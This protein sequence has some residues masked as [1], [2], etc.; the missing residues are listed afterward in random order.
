MVLIGIVSLVV[1][2]TGA[3][4]ESLRVQE[5]ACRIQEDLFYAQSQAVVLRKPHCVVFDTTQGLYH[6][7]LADAQATPVT[8]PVT[9]KACRVFLRKACD[10]ALTLPCADKYPDVAL[11]TADFDGSNVLTFSVLGM[12]MGPDDAPLTSGSVLL[13][14]SGGTSRRKVTIDAMTGTAGVQDPG[15]GGGS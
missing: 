15:P 4:A 11:N 10:L 13:A 8:D 3:G 2:A 7:A 12:P 6:V 1:V 14:N 9:R 5:A